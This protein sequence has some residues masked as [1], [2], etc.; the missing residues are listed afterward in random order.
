LTRLVVIVTGKG[1]SSTLDVYICCSYLTQWSSL[2][3]DSS[4]NFSPRRIPV[5]DHTV[6]PLVPTMP[7]LLGTGCVC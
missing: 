4:P 6:M 1:R 2:F 3:N 5:T 7:E